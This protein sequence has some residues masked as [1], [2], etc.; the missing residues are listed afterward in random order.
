MSTMFIDKL[1]R[2]AGNT[3]SVVG[4]GV[5]MQA[6]NGEHSHIQC[7]NCNEWGHYRNKCPKIQGVGRL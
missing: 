3:K 6:T 7:H 1:S 4:R 2:F 5:A